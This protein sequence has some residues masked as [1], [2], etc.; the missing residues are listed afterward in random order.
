MAVKPTASAYNLFDQ[1]SID[2][3]RLGKL[4]PEQRAFLEGQLAIIPSIIGT[5]CQA[6]LL[7]FV[8][9]VIGLIAFIWLATWETALPQKIALGA[10]IVAV[11]L[12]ILGRGIVNQ[13]SRRSRLQADLAEGTVRRLEGSL[14]FGKRGYQVEAGGQRLTVPAFAQSESLSP[15]ISY[16]FYFLPHSATLLSAEKISAFTQHQAQGELNKILAKANQF[17]YQALGL[18]R[19]GQ[20]AEEQVSKVRSKLV[21]PLIFILLP[22]GYL[23]YQLYTQISK[24]GR[25]NM[26][27]SFAVI[28]FILLALAVWGAITLAKTLSDLSQRMVIAI[29][30]QGHKEKHVSTDSD[31]HDSTDYYYVIAGQR[32]KVSSNAYPA[33]ID[34]LTYRAYTPRVV[35]PW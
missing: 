12:A 16:F 25:I 23:G 30:G 10:V 32:F 17:Q 26:T 13:K 9:G 24:N 29:E 2:A 8:L 4:T 6:V 35:R 18:N 14:T 11:I 7:I 33:L 28:A 3:N 22:L 21:A 5:G 27:S 34:G 20:L 1:D 19:Q 15:G 31:G